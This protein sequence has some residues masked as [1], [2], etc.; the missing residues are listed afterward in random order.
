MGKPIQKY[1]S[2]RAILVEL[3][4]LVTKQGARATARQ[5][6]IPTM[7]GRISEFVGGKRPLNDKAIAALGY[8]ASVPYYRKCRRPEKGRLMRATRMK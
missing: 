1:S 5:F 2:T 6:G 7:H 4:A 8:D 3:R